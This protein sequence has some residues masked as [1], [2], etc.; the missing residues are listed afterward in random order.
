MSIVKLNNRGVRSV[1]SFGSATSGSMAFIKKITAS[2]SSAVSFVDG[3]SDVVLDNTY[4]EY[5]FTFKNMHRSTG[6]SFF[7]FN[8]SSDGGSNYNVTKTTNFFYTYHNDGS[9][10]GTDTALNYVDGWDKAQDTGSQRL[11]NGNAGN[12]ECTSGYLH[13]FNPSS[14][15]FVKHF[16]AH[17]ISN[18]SEYVESNYSSGYGNTTSAVDAIKFEFSSGNIDTGDICLY[19]IN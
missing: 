7:Q 18:N 14:T 13:L 10:G 2:S 17:C 12:D 4:K 15:T 9:G 5:L 16:M 6:T 8:M 3:S 11:S 19:G 1:T